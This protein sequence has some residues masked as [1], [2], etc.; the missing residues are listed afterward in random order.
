M[1]IRQNNSLQNILV[2]GGAGYIG[3]ELCRQLLET[4]REVTIFDKLVHGSEGLSLLAPHPHLRLINADIRDIAAVNRALPGH[5][6]A[7]LLAAVVGQ[8]ACDLDPALA[9]ETNY[10]AAL[11]ILESCACHQVSRFVFT[12]TDSCYGAREGEKLDELSELAPLSLYA[13]LKAKAEQRIISAPAHAG[14]SPVV[15]RLATVYG[16]SYRPRFDLAVNLLVREIALKKKAAIFSGEQWRP[17]V[18]VRDVAKAFIMA[19]EAPASLVDHQVFNVGSNEQ[20][21]QFKTLGQLL[22]DLDPDATVDFVPATPDLRDYFVE[23]GKIKAVLGFA[24]SVGLF[25]GMQEIRREILAGFPKNPYDPK[26]RNA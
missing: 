4:G 26:W 22:A 16:L 13:E 5:Q 9:L 24:P 19:L 20:N 10:L 2:F 6:A 11:N 7:V 21:V 14:F 23:F 25:E 17:L 1:E 3:L 18:H 15:L 8:P 12:S